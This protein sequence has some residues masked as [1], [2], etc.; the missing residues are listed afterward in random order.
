M[1]FSDDRCI[2]LVQKRQGVERLSYTT[3]DL[4]R[5]SFCVRR[6]QK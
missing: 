6:L 2:E 1:R 4:A 5:L 3:L